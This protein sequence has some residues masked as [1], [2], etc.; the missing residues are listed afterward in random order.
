ME[1]DYPKTPEQ[2]K[3][4]HRDIEIQFAITL[5][6]LLLSL[7]LLIIGGVTKNDTIIIVGE[8]IG[9]AISAYLIIGMLIV[10]IT[11]KD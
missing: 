4:Y 8:I 11:D 2:W 9:G 7:S 10:A 6:T 1:D 5:G 3:K